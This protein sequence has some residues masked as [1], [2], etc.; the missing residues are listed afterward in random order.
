MCVPRRP[1]T[2]PATAYTGFRLVGS[3]SS[4]AGRVEVEAGGTWG[5]L[6]A[7]G[8]DLPD[9]HVLCHHLGCGAA[10]AVPPG[11]FFGGGNGPLRRDTFGC[12]GSERHPGE[13][14]VVVLGE[15]A[16]P[17]GH[18]AAVNCSGLY[19]TRREKP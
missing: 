15:P 18:T 19:G 9:A 14:P 4:C 1:N 2:L 11:G 3:N 6:C 13:C 8:W 12:D 5:S 7:T 16:C 10:A 17:P